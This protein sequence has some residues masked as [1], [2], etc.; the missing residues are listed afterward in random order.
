MNLS[1]CYLWMS[2]CNSEVG[3]S[4]MLVSIIKA[5]YRWRIAWEIVESNGHTLATCTSGICDI[6]DAHCGHTYPNHARQSCV[7][8]NG[9]F[10]IPQSCTR[11]P[12]STLCKGTNPRKAAGPIMESI[13]RKWD[14]VDD[15]PFPEGVE[16]V[17][18]KHDWRSEIGRRV[19]VHIIPPCRISLFSTQFG[20]KRLRYTTV[21]LRFVPR[22]G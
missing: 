20:G 12:H 6:D 3:F 11:L 2:S 1:Y 15:R 14:I 19:E 5:Y 10:P 13:W 4:V 22:R 16:R 21:S 7:E 9:D 17:W 8:A 18:S